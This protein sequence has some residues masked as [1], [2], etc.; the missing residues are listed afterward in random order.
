MLIR[1]PYPAL[2]WFFHWTVRPVMGWLMS[3]TAN[4]HLVF[5]MGDALDDRQRREISDRVMEHFA[6]VPAECAAF[7]A[8]GPEFIDRYVDDDEGRQ[9]MQKMEAEWPGGWLGITAHLG[10]WEVLAQ[11]HKQ[12]GSRPMAGIIAKRQP[13]PHLNR[14]VERFRGKHGMGTL[15]RDEPATKLVRLLKSGHAIGTA[16]DQDIWT[17]PGVFLDFLGR[18]AYT[19]LGPA[20]LAWSANVPI[21]VGFMLREGNRL[22]VQLNSPIYPDRSRPKQEEILRLTRAWNDEVQ[23]A[24]RANPEQWAWFH[25]RWSTT[26]ELLEKRSRQHR[27]LEAG[28]SAGRVERSARRASG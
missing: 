15:Y 2:K 27:E 22:R 20:R 10:N 8:M 12:V 3:K 28:A 21:L 7:A 24:I 23:E 4:K 9:V 16:G 1:V 14:V 18:P 13:N 5:A 26:P 25:D 17:L 11:W 6:A 19:P